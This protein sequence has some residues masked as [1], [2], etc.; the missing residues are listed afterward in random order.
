M[1]GTD[2]NKS[3]QLIDGDATLG[4]DGSVDEYRFE[5]SPDK[6]P[7]HTYKCWVLSKKEG[8]NRIFLPYSI[9]NTRSGWVLKA[10]N[11]ETE[12]TYQ[13]ALEFL[14]NADQFVMEYLL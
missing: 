6:H 3:R 8:R 4:F 1:V 5:T 7:K 13:K 14:M 9:S 12:I 2:K 10:E 11:K